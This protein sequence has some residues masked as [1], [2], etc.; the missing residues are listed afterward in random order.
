MEDEE[1]HRAELAGLLFLLLLTYIFLGAVAFP[2]SDDSFKFSRQQRWE[3]LR[4][5][6]GDRNLDE[7]SMKRSDNLYESLK[8]TPASTSRQE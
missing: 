7:A 3:S 1:Q 4:A 2:S 8:V 6:Q 5:R